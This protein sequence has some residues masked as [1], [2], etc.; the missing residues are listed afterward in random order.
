M[1]LRPIQLVCLALL[2]STL[3]FSDPSVLTPASFAMQSS[4]LRAL[5]AQEYTETWNGL[6]GTDHTGTHTR[7]GRI[8]SVAVAG[9]P[10]V[11]G[12]APTIRRLSPHRV[13]HASTVG[14]M[15]RLAVRHRIR[16]HRRVIS[17]LPL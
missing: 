4:Y 14:S 12:L 7:T 5:L 2:L 6:T 11:A 8:P 17:S 3:R 1:K 16:P 15:R 13:D 10:L 9:R